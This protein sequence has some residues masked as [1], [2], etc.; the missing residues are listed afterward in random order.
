MFAAEECILFIGSQQ[1]KQVASSLMHR[2]P[3]AK[4]GQDF[5][6]PYPS[7]LNI[8]TSIRSQLRSSFKVGNS[9]HQKSSNKA[10]TEWKDAQEPKGRKEM[11]QPYFTYLYIHT[12][13]L[14]MWSTS[15]AF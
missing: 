1:P 15:F 8:R 4:A 10:K 11:L 5:F 7:L 12:N 3:T 6:Y 13:T 2:T 14:S 9:K